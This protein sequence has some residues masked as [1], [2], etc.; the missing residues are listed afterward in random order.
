MSAGSSPSLIDVDPEGDTPD[1]PVDLEGAAPGEPAAED[2]TLVD[3]ELSEASS[4]AS[5]V[6]DLDLGPSD[7]IGL[8]AERPEEC[9]VYFTRTIRGAK[10]SCVCGRELPCP[11][12]GHRDKLDRG[13]ALRAPMGFYHACPVTKGKYKGVCDG[14]VDVVRRPLE[15][16]EWEKL[17]E[18]EDAA[19]TRVALALGDGEEEQGE[20]DEEEVSVLSGP[21][22]VATTNSIEPTPVRNLKTLEQ[23]I[24]EEC[25][26]ELDSFL[27]EDQEEGEA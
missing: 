22:A 15:R 23:S 24:D 10:T 14:R 5:E 25:K 18:E 16:E 4:I 19:M 8:V 1:N 26:R 11:R 27:M 20:Q 13:G 12:P 6:T 7:F 17:L 2:D 9:R 21:P 3:E